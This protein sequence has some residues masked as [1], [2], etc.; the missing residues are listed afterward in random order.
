[1][2]AP[3][4]GPPPTA[5]YLAADKGPQTLAVIIL[6][7]AL[8]LLVVALRLFTRLK[9]VQSLS[10]DDFAICLAMVCVRPISSKLS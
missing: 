8:A 4:N 7:P 3:Q 9:I 2:A 10:H 1:M 5:E 6:F